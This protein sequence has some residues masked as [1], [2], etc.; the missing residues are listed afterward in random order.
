MFRKFMVLFLIIVFSAGTALAQDVHLEIELTLQKPDDE[1]TLSGSILEREQDLLVFS[2]I[3]P[4]Y[5]VSVPGKF[6]FN[7]LFHSF[8]ENFTLFIP[9]FSDIADENKILTQGSRIDGVYSGDLFEEAKTVQT[10]FISVSDLMTLIRSFSGY[11]DSG[12]SRDLLNVLLPGTAAEELN[13]ALIEYSL[14]DNGKYLTLNVIKDNATIATISFDFSISKRIEIL[15]GYAE[16]GKNYYLDTEVKETAEN[17]V[18][19]QSALYADAWK[20]GYRDARNNKAVLETTCSFVLLPELHEILINGM[21]VPSNGLES[22]MF[23]GTMSATK[24]PDLTMEF[25]FSG[26]EDNRL[27]VGIRSAENASDPADKT[28]VSLE[29]IRVGQGM[30]QFTNEISL[31]FLPF[32]TALIQAL[33]D[34][35][36]K[37]FV[38]MN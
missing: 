9:S 8:E 24:A 33:P 3:F 16:E 25:H 27:I 1:K 12:S 21:F 35:Y 19:I 30:N 23:R 34:G 2:G 36:Q 13:D 15:L 17:S 5:A 26:A 31:N 28:I 20:K 4:E 22:M 29:E 32:Y 10:G 37:L 18:K 14:F 7:S 38:M 11:K 6:D